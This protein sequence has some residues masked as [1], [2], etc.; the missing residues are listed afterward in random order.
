MPLKNYL[1]ISYSAEYPVYEPAEDTFLL[2]RETKCRGKVLEV[3]T[4]SGLIAIYFSRMGLQVDAVD[5]S[6]NSLECARY[7]C[8]L[9]NAKVNLFHSDLFQAVKGR[10]DT[11][12]FNPPYL[13]VVDG[14]EGSGAW[15]G[16]VD[17]FAVT[18]RFLSGASGHLAEG[19][20]IYLILSDL[21]NIDYL[22]N[23]FK[24]FHF[25]LLGSE[26]FETETIHAYELKIRR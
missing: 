22:V 14:I 1:G 4:G 12:L 6:E 5:I 21:T 17:G 3:G 13:P 8:S 25:T 26:H 2:L 10:Y 7:N 16:G 24:H 18:R 11:I 20:S 9:N 19:G 15:D 23:E